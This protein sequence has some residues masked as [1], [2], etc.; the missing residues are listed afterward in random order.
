MR[1]WTEEA[2]LRYLRTQ[3]IIPTDRQFEFAKHDAPGLTAWGAVD[4]LCHY[5]GYSRVLVFRHG[6]S[7]P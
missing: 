6:M 2:T 1:K 7:R 3:G 5:C 4:F